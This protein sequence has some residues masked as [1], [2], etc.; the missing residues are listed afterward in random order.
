MDNNNAFE[1]RVRVELKQIGNGIKPSHDLFPG[2]MTELLNNK[3]GRLI[4]LKDKFVNM[5]TKKVAA[6]ILCLTLALGGISFST[7]GNFRAFAAE[8]LDKIK[9]IFVLDNSSKVVEKDAKQYPLVFIT[10]KSTELSDA[11]LSKKVGFKVVFPDSLGNN[12]KLAEKSE[13]IHI[14]NIDYIEGQSIQKDAYDAIDN[15]DKFQSLEKYNPARGVNAAYRKTSGEN[16]IVCID[17][18]I[19]SEEFEKQGASTNIKVKIVDINGIKTYWLD[20]PMPVYPTVT[21]D[22]VTQSDIT[23]KPTSIKTG[24]QLDWFSKGL[25]FSINLLAN[26]DYS[27][28]EIENAAKVIIDA[29]TK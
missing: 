9:T 20:I 17:N 21:K 3:K 15:I 26:Q 16:I 6:A 19:D 1:E 4:L 10:T 22:G 24:H 12:F 29:Y 25:H 7:S 18:H 23:Q 5:G 13:S 11:E 14:D 8:T 2:I 27:M 28:Q